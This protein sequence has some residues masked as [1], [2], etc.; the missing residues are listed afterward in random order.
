MAISVDTNWDAGGQGRSRAWT[1]G[2]A[3]VLTLWLVLVAWLGTKGAF[4]ASPTNPPLGVLIA[5]VAPLAVFASA[6]LVSDRFRDFVLA[7]DLRLLTAFQAWRVLGGMFLVLY[8]YGMLSPVFAF[9]AGLGDFAVGISAPFVAWAMM[10]Q[11][12]G[13]ES[14]VF[15]LTI[16][17]LLDFVGAIAT[18]VLT[19]PSALGVFADPAAS[20]NMGEVPL[21]L[22]PTFAVPLWT[23]FHIITLL[24]LR[25]FTKLRKTP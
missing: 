5:I 8:A 1:W 25:R 6:Y 20:A 2:V 17:G 14:R 18:G 10:R 19:S 22:I 9:P 23:I 16:A 24:Q 4:Q 21:S 3:A 11:S 7:I 12:A 13:W 15:W